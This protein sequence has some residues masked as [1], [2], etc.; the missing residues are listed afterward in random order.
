MFENWGILFMLKS[1]ILRMHFFLKRIYHFVSCVTWRRERFLN[2]VDYIKKQFLRDHS[3]LFTY[4]QNKFSW[5][6]NTM[7]K[8]MLPINHQI[9]ASFSLLCIFSQTI[10]KKQIFLRDFTYSHKPKIIPILLIYSLYFFAIIF[11]HFL[12]SLNIYYIQHWNY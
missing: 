12:F 10:F 5:T 9:L 4:D 11:I 3:L 6:A 2:L 1:Y 7:R 8:V